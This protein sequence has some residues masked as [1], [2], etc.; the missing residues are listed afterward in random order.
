MC[1]LP[2]SGKSTWA[3]EMV[4]G[5]K[6]L[7]VSRDAIRTMLGCGKYVFESIIEP[8]VKSIAH[9]GIKEL[10]QLADVIIDETNLN[11]EK[12]RE[13]I[14]IALSVGATPIIIYCYETKGNVERRMAGDSR[15]YTKE[16]W[17]G[18]IENMLSAMQIPT[19]DECKI[20]KV[21]IGE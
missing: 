10:L 12:R 1:G 7:C 3:K 18:V 14:D 19:E 11:R 15:G 6:C 2:G 9:H 5:K 8:T 4:D 20:L 21:G 13:L 16:K 17:T